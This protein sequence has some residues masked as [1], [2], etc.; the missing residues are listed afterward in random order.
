[1]YDAPGA[2]VEKVAVRAFETGSAVVVDNQVG[3]GVKVKQLDRFTA[4]TAD[5]ATE[6]AIG[7]T[8]TLFVK[9]VHELEISGA[10]AGAEE[11]DLIYIDPDDDSLALDTGAVGDLPLGVIQ[12]IDTSRTPDVARV[13]IDTLHAFLAVAA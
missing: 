13:N 11:G 1:M 5:E 12:Q 6:V 7:E 3:F 9:G 2:R 8:F 4:P 10:L